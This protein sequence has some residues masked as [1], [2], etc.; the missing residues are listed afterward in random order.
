MHNIV[1][2]TETLLV[3]AAAAGPVATSI[4]MHASKCSRLQFDVATAI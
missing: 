3:F 1:R 2:A 4:K